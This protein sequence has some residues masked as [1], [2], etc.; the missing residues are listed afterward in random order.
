M[1]CSHAR[2][3]LFPTPEKALL[4]IETPG[5]MGH[6]RD[7]DECQAFF[8][9][10][11]GLSESLRTKAGVEP[12]PDA[13]R[14]RTARLGETHKAAARRSPRDRK[15]KIPPTPPGISPTLHP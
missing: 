11:R 10:Q 3:T 4:T 14:E 9:R 7:C 1:N 15:Q 2:N 13:L 6:L 8:E 5:A 12:A